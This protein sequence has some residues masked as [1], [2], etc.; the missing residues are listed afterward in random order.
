MQWIR[1]STL[2]ISTDA[3]ERSSGERKLAEKNELRAKNKEY[4]EFFSQIIQITE[5]FRSAQTSI[6]KQ[7]EKD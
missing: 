6:C 1:S 3:N 2:Q 4:E 5:F 7:I